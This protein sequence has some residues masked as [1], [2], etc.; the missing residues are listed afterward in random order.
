MTR[1]G[2][3]SRTK[4]GEP[5]Y[6]R[7]EWKR[8]GWRY[9]YLY[10]LSVKTPHGHQLLL[11]A[12]ILAAFCGL[13]RG[14]AD[15]DRWRDAAV[16][17]APPVLLLMI[18][19][20]QLEFTHYLRYVLPVLGFATVGIGSLWSASTRLVSLQSAA[21]ALPLAW[22]GYALASN[23]PHQ[24]AY[25]NELAGGP[26]NGHK[27]LLHDGFDYGQDL[28]HAQQLC[29]TAGEDAWIVY[30]GSYRA[31]DL[32]LGERTQVMW[33]LSPGRYFVSATPLVGYRE[34]Y[35]LGGNDPDPRLL[36]ALSEYPFRRVK[37]CAMLIVTVPPP[38]KAGDLR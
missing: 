3:T 8:G 19:S 7:G 35:V 28:F 20:E 29:E 24:L 30:F 9:Y 15:P 33:P 31:E 14:R 37:G 26:A 34:H 4:G 36:G 18:A 5:S 17:W 21:I 38:L 16:L 10:G 2:G 23:Y 1:K 13:A 12:A 32:G 22:S 25:F 27:H 6:L 11:A